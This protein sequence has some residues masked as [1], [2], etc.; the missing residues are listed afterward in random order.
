MGCWHHTALPCSEQEA[1]A[2]QLSLSTKCTAHVVPVNAAAL[3]CFSKDS[4]A[5]QALTGGTSFH[6][7][8]DPPAMPPITVKPSA[9]PKQRAQLPTSSASAACTNG[10]SSAAAPAPLPSLPA[11]AA[12][13]AAPAN[14]CS[15]VAVASKLGPPAPMPLPCRGDEDFEVTVSVRHHPNIRC[16]ASFNTLYSDYHVAE[17][18]QAGLLRSNCGLAAM[19]QL[20]GSVAASSQQPA[21]SNALRSLCM[22]FAYCCWSRQHLTTELRRQQRCRL[23]VGYRKGF[24]FCCCRWARH[25]TRAA[26][27]PVPR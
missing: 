1:D 16:K 13:A 5:W 3:Q 25:G 18:Q 10:E 4:T 14:G 15:K 26:A 21:Q 12:A 17:L 9:G 22:L 2:E 8:A 11:A 6:P 19:V 7:Q 23:N 20:V 24:R 27:S